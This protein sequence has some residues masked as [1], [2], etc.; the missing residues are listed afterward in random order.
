LISRQYRGVEAAFGPTAWK[1]E[2]NRDRLGVLKE[3]DGATDDGAV[4]C[5]KVSSLLRM[6]ASGKMSGGLGSFLPN[7]DED[8]PN[9]ADELGAATPKA[10]PTLSGSLL[11][12]PFPARKRAYAVSA[13]VLS[14]EASSLTLRACSL[15]PVWMWRRHLP[16]SK[17]DP[18][19][20]SSRREPRFRRSLTPYSCRRARWAKR[21]RPRDAPSSEGMSL[22][23]INPS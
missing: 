16:N 12:P 15:P 20:S 22:W 10:D 17:L 2:G 9:S 1:I 23:G 4:A 21:C 14:P 6:Y 8:I 11:C 19:A 18:A 13:Q 3:L 5:D 7:N